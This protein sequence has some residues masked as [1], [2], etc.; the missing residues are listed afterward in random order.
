MS[1]PALLRKRERS[2]LLAAME[3]FREYEFPLNT[4]AV[5]AFLYVCENEGLNTSELA[6]VSRM[7]VATA[8]RLA[9]ILA[10]EDS[11]DANATTQAVFE[12]KSSP[13]DKR[14]KFIYLT[15]R[16]RKLRDELEEIIAEAN[17]IRPV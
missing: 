7:Y 17:P 4:R 9:R 16:G 12:F 3:K 1:E 13:D 6:Y 15:E 5:L 14:F 8:A 11:D 2:S 10:G